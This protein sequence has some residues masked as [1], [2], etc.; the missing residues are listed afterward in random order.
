MTTGANNFSLDILNGVPYQSITNGGVQS[1][2]STLA[3]QL[4]TYR[5]QGTAVAAIGVLRDL[6][7][8]ILRGQGGQVV[9]TIIVPTANCELTL[10]DPT[11]V[12]ALTTI[13]AYLTGLSTANVPPE[14]ALVSKQSFVTF[15]RMLA[16]AI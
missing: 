13:R 12:T 1:A 3:V 9:E 11:A 16:D 5:S 6:I 2:I 10:S 4:S 7:E 8:D 15:V 14:G